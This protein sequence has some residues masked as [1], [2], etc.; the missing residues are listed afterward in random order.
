[1]TSV[2]FGDVRYYFN[3][4]TGLD[5]TALTEYPDA[6]VWPVRLLVLL[7]GDTW[8][9][10]P[11]RVPVHVPASRRRLPHP[12]PPPHRP[13]PAHRRLVLGVLRPRRGARVLPAAG[14]VPRPA[15]RRASVRCCSTV[16]PGRRWRW[17]RPPQ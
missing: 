2:R 9:A 10:L 1:M 15:R 5:P 8:G 3:G 4:V 7:T 12:H 13:Q 17:R 16:P 6:G 14:S 11:G